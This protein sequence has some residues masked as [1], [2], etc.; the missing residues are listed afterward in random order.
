MTIAEKMM[1]K[2]GYREGSG[3]SAYLSHVSAVRFGFQRNLVAAGLG[4]NN[5][6]IASA[7]QFKKTDRGAGVIQQ[8]PIKAAK[9]VCPRARTHTHTHT[10]I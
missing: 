8:A 2:M 5:Q 1:M 7:L 3:P 10:A 6:G 9:P 4:R